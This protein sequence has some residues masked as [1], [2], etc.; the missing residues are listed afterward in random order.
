MNRRELLKSIPILAALP[1]NKMQFI[2][3]DDTMSD[4]RSYHLQEGPFY[5]FVVDG[6]NCD[7]NHFCESFR[8]TKVRGCVIAAHD[9]DVENFVR[10]YKLEE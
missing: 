5:L 10:I 3:P 1:A 2:N 6:M 8:D 7:I 9:G 4:A